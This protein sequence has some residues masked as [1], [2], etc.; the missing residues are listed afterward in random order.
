MGLSFFLCGEREREVGV[1]GAGAGAR[2]TSQQRIHMQDS[3]ARVR[4]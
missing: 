4:S 2:A 1:K 3:E